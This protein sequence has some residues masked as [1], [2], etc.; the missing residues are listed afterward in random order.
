MATLL[1]T[2]LTASKVYLRDCY[3]TLEIAGNADGKDSIEFSRPMSAIPAMA[4][5]QELVADATV[6]LVITPTADETASGLASP[7]NVIDA[8]DFAEV[9]STAIAAPLQTFRKTFTATGA[10][11]TKVDVT[12]FAANA[13]PYKF[14]ILDAVVLCSTLT[15]ATTCEL[16]DQAA[17]AGTNLVSFG[18]AATGPNRPS[19]AFTTSQVVSQ[20]NSTKGLFLNYDRAT[21]GEVIVTVRRES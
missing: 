17:G 10:T 11:G 7:P 21:A 3:A 8:A 9:T 12:L 13:L 20:S 2:N 1:V 19:V 6:S 15:A 5:L 4:G 16:R 18:T 14:R